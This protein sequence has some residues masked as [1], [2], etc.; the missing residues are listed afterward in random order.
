MERGLLERMFVR[1]VAAFVNLPS[2]AGHANK[3]FC[4]GIA[5]VLRCAKDSAETTVQSNALDRQVG[6]LL[7]RESG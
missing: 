4:R 2:P 7:I 1:P 3:L 5:L 6:A